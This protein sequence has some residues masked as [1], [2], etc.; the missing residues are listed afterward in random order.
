MHVSLL[1]FSSKKHTIDNREGTYFKMFYFYCILRQMSHITNVAKCCIWH[2]IRGYSILFNTRFLSKGASKWRFLGVIH[3]T[4]FSLDVATGCSLDGWKAKETIKR[5][6]SVAFDYSSRLPSSAALDFAFW[7][8]VQIVR[9]GRIPII[10]TY[11]LVRRACT[12]GTL[13]LCLF[14]CPCILLC[15]VILQ[16]HLL[17]AKLCPVMGVLL[18]G[19]SW[20]TVLSKVS[21]PPTSQGHFLHTHLSPVLVPRIQNILRVLSVLPASM[22]VSLWV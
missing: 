4:L 21:K 17:S 5:M 20:S 13:T 1:Y 15:T 18:R 7:G 10:S 14:L 19:V 12:D 9:Q 8:D 3:G 2:N 11:D 16:Y 22:A 6:V